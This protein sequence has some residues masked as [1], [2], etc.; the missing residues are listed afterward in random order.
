MQESMIALNKLYD[1]MDRNERDRNA[2]E[3]RYT[4]YANERSD[5]CYSKLSFLNTSVTTSPIHQLNANGKGGVSIPFPLKLHEMLDHI[6]RNGLASVVSWQSHGRCFLVHDQKKFVDEIMPTYFRQTKFASFQRQLN[7]YGFNRVTSGRDRGGYYHELFLRGKRFL[8]HRIQRIKIKGT[9]VRKA[10]SPETEPQFYS[11][12]PTVFHVEE[13]APYIMA[14]S[15]SSPFLNNYQQHPTTT[16]MPPAMLPTVTLDNLI[17]STSLDMTAQLTEMKSAI[18][19]ALIA[20]AYTRQQQQQQQP[21]LSNSSLAAVHN[22]GGDLQQLIRHQTNKINRAQTA[23]QQAAA[24]LP[25]VQAPGAAQALTRQQQQPSLPNNSLAAVQDDL[26]Q[27]IRQQTNKISCAQTALQQA[28][29]AL[30]NVQAPGAQQQQ[31]TLP[32]SLVAVHNN[33]DDLQQLIRQQTNKISCAQTVLQQAAAALP[34]T[35]APMSLFVRSQHQ[36]IA[37]TSLLFQPPNTSTSSW[38]S[39]FPQQQEQPELPSPVVVAARQQDDSDDE[40]E[41]EFDEV[42]HSLGK[43]PTEAAT[44]SQIASNPLANDSSLANLFDMIAD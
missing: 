33:G 23:L 22:G 38:S 9:G 5:D 24:A 32:N 19:R 1:K 41:K 17:P 27:L 37:D 31:P 25:I 40:S 11:M 15:L 42:L 26:Q 4:D 35:Q 6:E 7:L 30:P 3:H 36:P 12:P 20:Q 39:S 13:D 34:N 21:T 14:S 43:L 16:I 10:S 2:V 28:A 29:A 44:P 18:N 8:C